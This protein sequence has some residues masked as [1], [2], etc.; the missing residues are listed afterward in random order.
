VTPQGYSQANLKAGNTVGHILRWLPATG[1]VILM[2]TIS[3]LA[4]VSFSQLQNSRFWREHS[5]EVLANAETFRGN[6]YSVLR[7]AREYVL[8]GQSAALDVSHESATDAHRQLTQLKLLTAD[9]PGQQERLRRISVGLD[10]MIADT[11]LLTDTRDAHGIEAAAQLESDGQEIDS[12]NRTVTDWQL[13]T[14]EEHRLLSLRSTNAETN[15]QN[16]EHLLIFGSVLAAVLVILANF[17]T[18]RAMMAMRRGHEQLREQ[19]AVLDLAQVIVRD[20]ESRIVQWNLGAERLFG[21]SKE[22]AQGRVSHELFQTEFP[23]PLGQIEE[24]LYRTGQWEGELVHRTHDGERLAVTSQWVLYR[25]PAGNPVRILEVDIDI[26]ERTRAQK[27]LEL[28]NLDLQQ[29]AYI[30]SHDL[31]TPLRTI[32]GFVELLQVNYS[33][34][35]DAQGADW[36]RRASEGAH[37]LERLIDNLL[38]YS[39]LDSRAESFEPVDCQAALDEALQGLEILVHQTGAH[40]TAD[41]LPTVMGDSTQLVQ[42]FQNLIGNGIKYRDGSS[43]RVH[44]SAKKEKDKWVFSVSDNGIGID[45]EHHER[46]F[47]LFR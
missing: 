18:R 37:R 11:K 34:Q 32:S 23:Q 47:E 22:E 42:L 5:Y 30:A 26:T 21:F 12:I 28:R 4:A 35:L 46:I 3:L 20:M 15:F 44:I 27:D 2:A 43:P 24:K 33:G 16:T 1:S 36:I 31:K 29:F 39:R 9:N 45:P 41:E 38:L 6:F 8:T 7:A 25:D 19:A 17:L 13:F 10:Q 14:D 40:V